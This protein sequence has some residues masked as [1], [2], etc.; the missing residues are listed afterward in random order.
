MEPLK[1]LPPLPPLPPL[2]EQRKRQRRFLSWATAIALLMAAL[3]GIMHAAGSKLF[4]SG[5]AYF[6]GQ[7]Q[8]AKS[9]R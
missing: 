1:P 7:G 2:Q 4:E 3:G 9:G 6:T 5:W 8:E